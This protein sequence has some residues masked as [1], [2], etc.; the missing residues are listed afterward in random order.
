M[1]NKYFLSPHFS[2]THRIRPRISNLLN[3]EQLYKLSLTPVYTENRRVAQI[4][5]LHSESPRNRGQFAS[6]YT[7]YGRSMLY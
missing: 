6:N 1:T 5:N 2:L 7:K 3:I 4:A